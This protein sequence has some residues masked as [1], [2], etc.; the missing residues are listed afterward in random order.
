MPIAWKGKLEDL[1]F[2]KET[3]KMW[4][5]GRVS[6]FPSKEEVSFLKWF[7]RKTWQRLKEND[8]D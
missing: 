6:T 5:N 8:G 3:E 1:C 2:R 4:S 7:R